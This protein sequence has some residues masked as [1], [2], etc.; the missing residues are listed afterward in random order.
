VRNPEDLPTW[1]RLDRAAPQLSGIYFLWDEDDALL[2]VGQT[3]HSSIRVAQHAWGRR[4]PFVRFSVLEICCEPDA[5]EFV[6][7]CFEAAYI[8]A[9]Q[10]PHNS[11]CRVSIIGQ[12]KGMDAAIVEAWRAH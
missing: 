9:L 12:A 4:I 2:Y 11:R 7:P 5:V 3:L 8:K 1:E 6:F 10:P